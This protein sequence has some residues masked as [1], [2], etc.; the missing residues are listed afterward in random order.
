MPGNSCRI[1]IKANGIMKS[2]RN[3]EYSGE[4]SIKVAVKDATGKETIGNKKQ[5]INQGQDIVLRFLKIR[6]YK[7]LVPFHA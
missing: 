2:L 5:K 6:I 1:W 4:V 3:Q 7:G